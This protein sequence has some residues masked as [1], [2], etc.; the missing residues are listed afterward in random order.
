MSRK[1][2]GDSLQEKRAALNQSS[3]GTEPGEASSHHRDL[4][5]CKLCN[6]L[7][8]CR[9]LQMCNVLHTV[10]S[11][12]KLDRVSKAL[13]VDFEILLHCHFFVKSYFFTR[14]LVLWCCGLGTLKQQVTL[15][16]T[17]Q[18][19]LCI[20]ITI[21]Y[22]YDY[23]QYSYVKWLDIYYYLYI[24]LYIYIT[25]HINTLHHYMSHGYDGLVHLGPAQGA[26]Q[27]GLRTAGTPERPS[28]FQSHCELENF[29]YTYIVYM[30]WYNIIL[31]LYIYMKIFKNIM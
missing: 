12:H 20:Y 11:M 2:D 18:Y 5:K 10:W 17:L 7:Q 31:S 26:P 25:I 3:L 24:T 15:R 4:A 27:L 19:I 8:L 16:Y 28:D 30:I 29:V 14:Y 21:L 23:T 1:F 9:W 22:K 6:V 13:Q